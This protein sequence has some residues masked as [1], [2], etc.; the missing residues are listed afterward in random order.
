[1]GCK[2]LKSIVI[3]ESVMLIGESAFENCKRL[4]EVTI[5]GI[6]KKIENCAFA[7]CNVI[8]TVKVPAKMAAY[9]KRRLPERLRSRIVEMPAEEEAKK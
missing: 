8:K 4:K 6:V 2:G 7:G 1:M 5:L 9:Y 3:P